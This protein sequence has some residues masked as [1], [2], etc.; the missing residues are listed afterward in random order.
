MVQHVQGINFDLQQQMQKFLIE[1][2]NVLFNMRHKYVDSPLITGQVDLSI[3]NDFASA[4]Q[5]QSTDDSD[6]REQLLHMSV[7]VLELANLIGNITNA[8]NF[9]LKSAQ[10]KNAQIHELQQQVENARMRSQS[11]IDQN[12]KDYETKRQEIEDSCTRKVQRYIDATNEL[13]RLNKDLFEKSEKQGK[14]I[15][16]LE[17]QVDERD[18]A[19]ETQRQ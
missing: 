5:I 17:I 12:Q 6:R 4:Q 14:K 19:I 9:E 2:H 18:K 15:K 16:V 8:L 3:K 13:E 10:I 1:C 7:S 11:T